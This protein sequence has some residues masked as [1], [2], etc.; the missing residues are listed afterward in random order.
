MFKEFNNLK[1]KYLDYCK[2]N[3]PARK[4]QVSTATYDESTRAVSSHEYSNTY[5][6][7]WSTDVKKDWAPRDEWSSHYTG[8]WS[9]EQPKKEFG[10][11]NSVEP[12]QEWSSRSDD[13]WSTPDEPSKDWSSNAGK[14]SAPDEPKKAWSSNGD[15]WSAPDEPKKDW[16]SNGDKW[17]ASDEPKKDWSSNG[18]KWNTSTQSQDRNKW[19]TST[20]PKAID[21]WPA[22]AQPKQDGSSGNQVRSKWSKEPEPIEDD[23]FAPTWAGRKQPVAVGTESKWAS[24]N[25]SKWDSSG[26]KWSMDVRKE[27][28]WNHHEVEKDVGIAEDDDVDDIPVHLLSRF[29][30]QEK[31]SDK[32]ASGSF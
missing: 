9:T 31:P 16:Y 8:K 10:P 13:K 7:K 15:K 23:E 28:S 18:D 12:K 2:A 29:G 24:S 19:S 27:K 22:S 14:W 3:I 11:R 6:D 17:S 5:S 20:A 30:Q 21:R 25:G 32:Y 26:D 4:E 1:V